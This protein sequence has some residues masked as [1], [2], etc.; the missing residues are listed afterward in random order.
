MVVQP[1][2][3][4]RYISNTHGSASWRR[5]TELALELYVIGLLETKPLLVREQST[6]AAVI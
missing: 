2:K 4:N 6:E 3:H 5:E 1:C